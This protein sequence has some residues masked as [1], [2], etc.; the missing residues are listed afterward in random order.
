MVNHESIGKYFKLR[1]ERVTKDHLKREKE[2]KKLNIMLSPIM[3]IF[4]FA[5]LALS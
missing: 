4:A 3:K 1:H 5:P 2:A